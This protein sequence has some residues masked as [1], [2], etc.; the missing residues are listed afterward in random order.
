MT[1]IYYVADNVIYSDNVVEM[2]TVYDEA[3]AVYEPVKDNEASEEKGLVCCTYLF[4]SCV[5]NNIQLHVHAWNRDSHMKS[6][7]MLA[8]HTAPLRVMNW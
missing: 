5:C 8:T 7:T 3:K 1:L 6:P 2:N 4:F